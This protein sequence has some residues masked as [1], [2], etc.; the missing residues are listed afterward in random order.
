MTLPAPETPTPRRRLRALRRPLAVA[1][2]L[3]AI[4]HLPVTPLFPLLRVLQRMAVVDQQKD[5]DYEKKKTE[6]EPSVPIELLELPKPVETANPNEPDNSVSL[7]ADPGGAAPA[8]GQPKPPVKDEAAAAKKEAAAAEKAKKASV[9]FAKGEAPEDEE[10][11]DGDKSDDGLPSKSKKKSKGKDKRVSRLPDEKPEKDAPKETIGLRGPLDD[12]LVGKPNVTLAMWFPT[13]REHA[14][15]G[16]VDK[17]FSCAPEWRPMI[18]QGVKPLT[19]VDGMLIVGEQ[20]SDP[21]G[22][23][24][25]LQHSMSPERLKG[26]ADGMVQSIGER[27]AWMKDGVAKVV[28]ARK[29]RV[30]FEHP[31][32]MVFMAPP[33]GWEAI[34]DTKEPLGMPASKGRAMSLTLQKPSRPL[35]RLGLKL[36]DRLTEMHLDVFANS[37]GSA[38]LQI[39]FEEESDAQALADAPQVSRALSQLFS[40]LSQVTQ[41]VDAVI[42]GEGDA[43][44]RLP[45]VDFDPVGKRITGSMHFAPRQT[46][47]ML[48]L[49]SKVVCPKPKAGAKPAGSAP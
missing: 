9:K 49:L 2:V 14:L 44:L 6:P 41:T 34:H 30:V 45:D 18:A 27:G 43:K 35:R 4:V 38:D 24:V 23:T 10:K 28:I 16:T 8:G 36:P 3:A 5:W 47:K 42:P 33:T 32:D 7:P 31:R 22:M 39:D 40:D 17:L 19:D 12:K 20:L 29:E 26:V 25:A 21:S 46:S 11:D 1:F 37:D 48:S 13:I 15:A